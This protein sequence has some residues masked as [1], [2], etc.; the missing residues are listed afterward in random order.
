MKQRKAAQH[1]EG[2]FLVVQGERPRQKGAPRVNQAPRFQE[3]GVSV[4]KGGKAQNRPFFRD[5]EPV[6][7][8]RDPGRQDEVRHEQGAQLR[9]EIREDSPEQQEQKQVF[10]K[11]EEI[12]MHRLRVVDPRKQVV[13]HRAQRIE[14]PD[15]LQDEGGQ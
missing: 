14:A 9:S 15:I 2:R 13:F 7:R 8:G 12:V 6:I 1:Q 5:H 3:S 11:I 4:Q 10:G